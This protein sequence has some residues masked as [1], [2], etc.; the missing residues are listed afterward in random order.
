[1]NCNFPVAFSQQL[2]FSEKCTFLYSNT[3]E[4]GTST[5]LDFVKFY[6]FNPCIY[7]YMI[8]ME[9]NSY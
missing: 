2:F 3:N 5:K 1:M 7:F 4:I 9:I 6:L 8:W